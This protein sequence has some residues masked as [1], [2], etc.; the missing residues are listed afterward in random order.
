MYIPDPI[1]Q[2]RKNRQIIKSS[3]LMS[4]RLRKITGAAAG[5]FIRT[6]QHGQ[7][8]HAVEGSHALEAEIGYV[9]LVVVAAPA[10][11]PLGP[12]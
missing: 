4:A 5:L 11:S 1:L 12:C 3:D 7:E 10:G 2:S 6:T 9:Q 8:A